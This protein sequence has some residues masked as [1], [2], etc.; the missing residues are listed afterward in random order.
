MTW[1][2]ILI[3]ILIVLIV[4]LFIISIL[5]FLNRK[6]GMNIGSLDEFRNGSIY[7]KSMEDQ[8]RLAHIEEITEDKSYI[9]DIETEHIDSI[10]FSSGYG[11]LEENDYEN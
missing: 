9:D 7:E 11:E 6:K 1:L 10:V 5:L 4:L 8:K 2:Y 3:D